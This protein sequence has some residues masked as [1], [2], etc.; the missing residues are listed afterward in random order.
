[1]HDVKSGKPIYV[2]PAFESITGIKP[3]VLL[4][5]FESVFNIIHPEDREQVKEEMNHEI[6]AE[7]DIEYRII[8]PDGE[9]RWILE[10]AFPIF[11]E[12]DEVYRICGVAEDI[13][14]RKL[15]NEA[16]T[17]ERNFVSA[18]LV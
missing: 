3:Q 1:M 15:A 14:E 6:T 13:T 9:V 5:N 7:H 8:R 18:V 12:H 17:R 4:E 2:S 11:N 10:R 16:L